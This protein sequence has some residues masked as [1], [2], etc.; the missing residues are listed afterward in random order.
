MRDYKEKWP[1]KPIE[2]IARYLGAGKEGGYPKVERALN[3]LEY[4]PMPER[5]D[6]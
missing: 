6:E 5:T 1:N 4:G 3:L 2:D